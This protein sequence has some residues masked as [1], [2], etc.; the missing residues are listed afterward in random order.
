MFPEIIF[1]LSPNTIRVSPVLALRLYNVL[2]LKKQSVES[3]RS[4]RGSCVCFVPRGLIRSIISLMLLLSLMIHSFLIWLFHR[5]RSILA[6][7][8]SICHFRCPRSMSSISCPSAWPPPSTLLFCLP[9]YGGL[10]CNLE[11]CFIML[12]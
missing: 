11:I 8:L 12:S 3:A 9:F 7:K 6:A 4:D 2:A 1:P 10:L 5:K